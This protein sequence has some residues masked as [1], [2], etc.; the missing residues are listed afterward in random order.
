M[1]DGGPAF[2]VVTELTPVF[3]GSEKSY[4]AA[5]TMGMSL[6]E[7]YAGMAICDIASTESDVDGLDRRPPGDIA[8]EAWALADAM[9][10]ERKKRQENN[11]D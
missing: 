10:A 2:P 7:W 5:Y 4:E 6:L 9:L 8:C 1:N 3:C 11:D